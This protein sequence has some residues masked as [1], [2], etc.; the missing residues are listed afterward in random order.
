MVT[1]QYLESNKFFVSFR[2]K[3][4]KGRGVFDHEGGTLECVILCNNIENISSA[5]HAPPMC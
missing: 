1:K 3:K 2:R 4:K 5:L